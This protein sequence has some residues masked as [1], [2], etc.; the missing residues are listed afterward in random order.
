[1]EPS[2]KKIIN[3]LIGLSGS[4]ATI[5]YLELISK[6]L[7]NSELFFEIKLV[8]TKNSLF[9]MEEEHKKN[10]KIS[11]EERE[12][13]ILIDENEWEWKKRG[14][15][16]LHIELRKWAD[17]LLIAPLSANTLAKLSNGLCDNL[18]VNFI[19]IFKKF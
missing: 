3:L 18:L 7:K 15:Q 17:I 5:K 14:D 9:F 6:F 8:A 16:I 13:P 2:N 4:I 19:F 11:F 12:I 1:M 10:L